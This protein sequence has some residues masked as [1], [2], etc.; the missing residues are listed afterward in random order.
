MII[1]RVKISRLP[2]GRIVRT[3]RGWTQAQD[4]ELC[5]RYSNEV[6]SQIAKDL[7]K[8]LDQIYNRAFTL[9]LKKSED[10]M[11]SY[12]SGRLNL[13][14]GGYGHR[15][16]KGHQPWNKGKKGWY[17]KGCERTWYKKG[18][19]PSNTKWDGCISLRRQGG[20]KSK[21]EMYIRLGKQKWMCYARYLVAKRTGRPVPKT[22]VVYHKDGNLLNNAPDNLEVISRGEL[23]RRN[24]NTQKTSV[25]MKRL[26]RELPDSFIAAH[27]SGGDPDMKRHLIKERPDLIEIYRMNIKL[28]REIKGAGK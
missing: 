3:G 26:W 9:G 28:K 22:H 13:V 16:P 17:P 5:R 27:M 21:R 25:A 23:V 15:Y 8:T 12:Q 4:R 11:K 10:F 7:G 18:N 1:R 20:P 14:E 24:H 6:A 2:D 19:E